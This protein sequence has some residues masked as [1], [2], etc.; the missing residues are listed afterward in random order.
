MVRLLRVAFPD[1]PDAGFHA[2][3][4]VR[5][6][7][8]ADGD[9]GVVIGTPPS[10]AS[11]ADLEVPGAARGAADRGGAGG[12]ATA[13]GRLGEAGAANPAANGHGSAERSGDY[14]SAAGVAFAFQ[15]MCGECTGEG[16]VTD[17][18]VFEILQAVAERD[19]LLDL[20][21]ESL[22]GVVPMDTV[23]TFTRDLAVR[24]RDEL[25]AFGL[26]AD[27]E[28]SGRDSGD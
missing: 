8:P 11:V 12:P 24:Y 7:L 3:P 23:E 27:A 21:D 17:A 16:D 19:G 25:L 28:P 15:I 5:L 2:R 1:E 22:D 4:A 6:E 14:L 9:P 20:A 13:G 10:P 18:D 26:L